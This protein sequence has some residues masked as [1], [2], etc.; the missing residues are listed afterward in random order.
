MG[1][2]GSGGTLLLPCTTLSVGA[3]DPAAVPHLT[4]MPYTTN[5]TTTETQKDKKFRPPLKSGL[6]SKYIP[7]PIPPELGILKIY[8]KYKIIFILL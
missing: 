2:A 4:H 8:S 3:V 5:T 1:P 7:K 6:K